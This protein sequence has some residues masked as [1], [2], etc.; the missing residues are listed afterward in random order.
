M[1]GSRQPASGRTSAQALAELMATLT[2]LLADPVTPDNAAARNVEIT[3]CHEQMAKIQEDINAENT[4]FAEA[5]AEV[6]QEQRR[7]QA[8]ADHLS[9]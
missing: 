4:C 3:K 6:L 1:A 5:R 9:L 8:E 2:T 7:L